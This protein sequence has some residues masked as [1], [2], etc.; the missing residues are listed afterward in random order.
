MSLMIR[1]AVA[2]I[3]VAA[4][5]AAAVAQQ[6]PAPAPRPSA[7]PQAPR[8][9]AGFSELVDGSDLLVQR[10]LYKPGNRTYWHSHEK[11]FLLMVE[12]G[13]AR[14]QKRGEPMKQLGLGDVDYTP[15]NVVHWHGAAPESEFVQV[16]VSFGGGITFLTPVTDAE[17]QGR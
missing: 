8:A 1:A 3:L 4:A 13:S 17:Y 2:A 15:P 16:G 11:G 9:E 5:S 7:A 10:R 6:S 12:R 14:A